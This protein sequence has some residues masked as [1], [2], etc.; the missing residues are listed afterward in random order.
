MQKEL[1]L[2]DVLNRFYYIVEC[3]NFVFYPKAI[4]PM[5]FEVSPDE[6]NIITD[7]VDILTKENKKYPIKCLEKFKSFEEAKTEA[8][9]LNNIPENKKR[10]KEWNSPEAIYK[11][12]TLIG[13]WLTNAKM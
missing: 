2:E 5:G 3:D 13:E 8:E 6:L 9:R 12:L 11:R 1:N 7:E 10:A 4:I